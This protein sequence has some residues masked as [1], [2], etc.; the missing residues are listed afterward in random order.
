MSSSDDEDGVASP[1]L[2]ATHAKKVRDRYEPPSSAE[3][4]RSDAEA[5]ESEEEEQANESEEE[6]QS[7]KRSRKK[8]KRPWKLLHTWEKSQ[9]EPEDLEHA[10]FTVHC[11]QRA[12]GGHTI[13]SALHD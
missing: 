8:D 10:L 2:G 4:A 13:V 3:D 1:E 6:E 7:K 5:T 11:V 12:H 9:Y